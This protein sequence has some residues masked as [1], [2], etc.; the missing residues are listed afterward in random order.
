VDDYFRPS[1]A[2]RDRVA[3]FLRGHFAAGGITPAELDARL[4]ATITARTYADLVRVLADLPVPAPTL[5]LASRSL[6][7]AGRLERRC[8]RLMYKVA[9]ATAGLRGLPLP[10]RWAIAGAACTGVTGAIV[11]LIVG[12]RAYAPTAAFAEIELG[13]PAALAGGVTGLAAGAI[14]AA[15][16]RIRRDDARSS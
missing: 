7:Q 2:E 12:L 10:A 15:V 8:R 13:L 6:P 3:A 5:Q 14:A 4:T 1:D 11:G 9:G 16:R